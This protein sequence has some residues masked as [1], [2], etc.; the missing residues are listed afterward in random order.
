[1]STD[2]IEADPLPADFLGSLHVREDR[3]LP[4]MQAIAAAGEPGALWLDEQYLE[5]ARDLLLLK[6]DFGAR[7]R[8]MPARRPAT[9]DELYR[10]VRRGQELLHADPAKEW[11]LAELARA[12]YLSPYHFQRAFT[13][14]FGKSPHRYRNELRLA[15]AHRLL[16]STEL[17][18][19][20]ICGAVGFASA[21]SFSTLYRQAYG[22]PP[23]V[24]RKLSNFR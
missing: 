18:V 16:Q 8:L 1:M 19:T 11:S 17:T 12:S 3:I 5:L 6:R 10:R 24:T 14:A 13:C 23:S 22:E 9:R 21:P 4:R 2:A 7:V 15:R 20:E